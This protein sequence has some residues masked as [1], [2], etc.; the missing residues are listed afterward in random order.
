MACVGLC[1]FIC[2]LHDSLSG[3]L[4]RMR[5]ETAY[6]IGVDLYA[7]QCSALGVSNAVHEV[8]YA[9]INACV[10]MFFHALLPFMI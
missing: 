1:C 4:V 6:R 9:E 10:H 8:S 5:S 7:L 2:A 3:R